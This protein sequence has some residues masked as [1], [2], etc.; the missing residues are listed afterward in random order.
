MHAP[1]NVKVQLMFIPGYNFH[2]YLKPNPYKD[3]VNRKDYCWADQD[4]PYF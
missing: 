2:M 1:L 4:I 3:T